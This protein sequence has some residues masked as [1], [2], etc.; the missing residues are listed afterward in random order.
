MKNYDFFVKLAEKKKY[1][2]EE[3]R[4]LETYAAEHGI[5]INK[6]CPDCYA[7][8]AAQLAIIYKPK[9]EK[10]AGGFVL[11]DDIDIVLDS[12]PHG[13][14]HVCPATCTD[15]NARKWIEAGIPRRFF[16]HIPEGE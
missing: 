13:R 12:Y 1:T 6:S 10:K 16:A 4:T 11:R 14:F 9:E 2:A 15:E 8:A 3:K 5:E 7:D